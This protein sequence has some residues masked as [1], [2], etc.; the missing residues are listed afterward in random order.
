MDRICD[1]DLLIHAPLPLLHSLATASDAPRQIQ[2]TV[3]IGSIVAIQIKTF[4][5]FANCCHHEG[6]LQTVPRSP[7]GIDC[8]L[9]L[10][11]DQNRFRG[12]FAGRYLPVSIDCLPGRLCLLRSKKH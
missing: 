7:I 3:A 11:V 8:V 12:D 10:G 5:K 6:V 4:Y 2:E 1:C 9:C